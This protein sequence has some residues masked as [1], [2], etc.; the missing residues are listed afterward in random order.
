MNQQITT[1]EELINETQEA[2]NVETTEVLDAPAVT[3]TKMSKKKLAIIAA[4]AIAVIAIALIIFTPSEFERVESKCVHIAGMVTGSSDYFM[5]DTLPDGS[6]L[7]DTEENVLEAIKYANEE[8]DSGTVLEVGE[9]SSANYVLIYKD[10]NN[11]QLT[12]QLDNPKGESIDALEIA[13]DDESAEILVDGEYKPL[14]VTGNG[15]VVNWAQEDPYE[16]TFYLRT[17]SQDDLNTFRVND[18]KVNGAWQNKGLDNNELSVYKI[19]KEDLDVKFIA[20][21]TEYYECEFIY[22]EKVSNLN[23]TASIPEALTWVSTS[24]VRVTQ[25]CTL[26]WSYDF[27]FDGVVR[28]WKEDEEIELLDVKKIEDYSD[29]FYIFDDHTEIYININGGTSINKDSFE[30]K[31]EDGTVY[32]ATKFISNPELMTYWYNFDYGIPNA[33]N[34]TIDISFIINIGNCEYNLSKKS[35]IKL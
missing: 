13:C 23:V 1:N 33:D 15:R 6:M 29:Y 5:L 30:V 21:T 9:E 31:C 12:V 28:S 11:I 25:N 16:K 27:T 19:T 26:N 22:G 4:A 14:N 17:I 7:P 3:K 18:I 20:N 10:E 8:G 35:F 34:E 24:R 32:N 2:Q